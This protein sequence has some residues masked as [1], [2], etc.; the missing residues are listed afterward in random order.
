MTKS[1]LYVLIDRVP[2]GIESSHSWSCLRT[3]GPIAFQTTGVVRSLASPL[4]SNKIGVF[5]VCTFDG[6][7]LLI[8][9]H[10]RCKAWHSHRSRSSLRYLMQFAVALSC[11]S[12][13]L[14]LRHRGSANRGANDQPDRE[15]LW[16]SL[17]FRRA[18]RG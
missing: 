4:S 17:A 6:E 13:F 18:L 12:Q 5:V 8:A 14:L 16:R 3:I 15:P 10:D 2:E 11:M 9:E 1:L 7:H